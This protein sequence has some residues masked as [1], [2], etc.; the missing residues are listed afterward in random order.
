MYIFKERWDILFKPTDEDI[1][2]P[3]LTQTVYSLPSKQAY[4]IQET[5]FLIWFTI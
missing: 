1:E 4:I 5:S 3:D 2:N